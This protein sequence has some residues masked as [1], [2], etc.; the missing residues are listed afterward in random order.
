[1]KIQT[2]LLRFDVATEEWG[3]KGCVGREGHSLKGRKFSSQC[4]SQ[5]IQAGQN[6]SFLC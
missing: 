1:M 4:Y 5:R 2:K 3:E 6:G